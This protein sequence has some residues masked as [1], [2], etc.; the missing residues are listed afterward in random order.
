[1]AEAGAAGLGAGDR[2][3]PVSNTEHLLQGKPV[4]CDRSRSAQVLLYDV[5]LI[6]NVG[7]LQAELQQAQRTASRSGGDCTDTDSRL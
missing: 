5:G 7:P 4:A 6:H 3:H 2:S 1:M